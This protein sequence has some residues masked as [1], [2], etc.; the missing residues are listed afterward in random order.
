MKGGVPDVVLAWSDDPPFLGVLN[1]ETLL[2]REVALP[3][4]DWGMVTIGS[5]APMAGGRVAAS[6][7]FEGPPVARPDPWIDGH[8]I[9]TGAL[10]DS[11]WVGVGSI[12]RNDAVYLSWLTSRTAIG[13]SG[14]T[15]LALSLSEGVLRGFVS[16]SS[17]LVETFQVTL[18]RYLDVPTPREEVWVAEWITIGG[19]MPYL[20]EVSQVIRADIAQ[21][22]VLAVRPYMAE[23]RRHK[24]RYVPTQGGWVVTELGLEIYSSQGQLIDA[25]ALPSDRIVWIRAGRD[26]RIYLSDGRGRVYVVRDPTIGETS[27]CAP[28]PREIRLLSGDTYEPLRDGG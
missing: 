23:W 26:G 24:N 19:A 25:F 2:L 21:G 20:I 6:A 17:G 13:S 11:T 3:V 14:D 18:P 1:L 8:L 10:G 22:R 15:V 4:H 7:F 28:L 9:A 5:V 27:A 12:P 16:E